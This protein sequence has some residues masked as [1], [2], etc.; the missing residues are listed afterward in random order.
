MNDGPDQVNYYINA[1]L[2]AKVKKS[3]YSY[4]LDTTR[5]KNGRY[6]LTIVPY[7]NGEKLGE[8]SYGITIKNKLNFWQQMFNVI[9]SPFSR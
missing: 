5:L 6:A 9:T 8:Y 7:Q 3:P 1:K 4:T 2:K